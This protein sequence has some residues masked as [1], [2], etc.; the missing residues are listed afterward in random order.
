[1]C[2]WGYQ[3]YT[4]TFYPKIDFWYSYMLKAESISGW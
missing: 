1:V 2:V 3:S 4:A